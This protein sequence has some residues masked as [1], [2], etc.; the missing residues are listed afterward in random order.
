MIKV[1][2]TNQITEAEPM[3][4]HASIKDGFVVVLM[5]GKEARVDLEELKRALSLFE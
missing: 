3:V 4:V 1:E 5:G 2:I